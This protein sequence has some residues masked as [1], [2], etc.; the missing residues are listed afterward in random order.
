MSDFNDIMTVADAR[1]VNAGFL[2][3]VKAGG[4]ELRKMA[5][6]INEEIVLSVLREDGI[7]R[8]AMPYTPMTPDRLGTDPQH[9]DVPVT[10]V[11]IEVT[12]GEYLAA[13]VDF[14]QPTKDLWFRSQVAPIYFKP[15]KTKTI[16]LHEAQLLA[17]NYPIRTYLE[18]VAKND[19]LAAED[20]FLI[21]TIE[22]CT[23]K[24]A[25]TNQLTTAGPLTKDTV[26]E[27]Q[28]AVVRN[29]LAIESVLVNE[30][31]MSDILKFDNSE[32]GG[33]IMKEIVD[34]G[35]KGEVLK[36]KAWFGYNWIQTNNTDVVPENV[37]Y[38]LPPRKYLGV[39]Y[40]LAD[41]EQW[42]EF[43][44]GVLSTNT[45]EII[46]RSILNAKGPLKQSIG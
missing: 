46:G 22:R 44:D 29:R 21:N 2:N 25:S 34:N 9:P 20:I 14:M 5:N 28:K 3:S 40:M 30:I 16:R 11:P 1:A 17:N 7:A 27:A 19:M 23:T 37:L 12:F 13:A 8:R 32:V 39:S 42:I 18:S 31:T 41:A 10:Y 24:F 38:W 35:P 43:R 26:A 45:R 15:I 4:E 36:Y 33:F 6:T